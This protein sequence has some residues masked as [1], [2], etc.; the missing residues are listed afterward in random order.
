[1]WT[2]IWFFTNILFVTSIVAFLFAHRSVTEG[3][4][5]E[6]GAVRLGKSIRIRRTLGIV[7]IVLFAA[8]ALSFIIN[9][10]VNG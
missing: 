3:R 4:R 9:M 1:M 8:M 2:G 5:M 6:V 10:K 7:S